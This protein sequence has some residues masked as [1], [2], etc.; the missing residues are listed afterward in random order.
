MLR[1]VQDGFERLRRDRAWLMPVLL[2]EC[3]LLALVVV[4]G[5]VLRPDTT[6]HPDR[7]T[8]NVQNCDLGTPG[9]AQVSFTVTNADKE[10]HDYQVHLLVA[11]AGSAQVGSGSVLVNHVG[12]GAT[13]TARALVPVT[14]GQAGATCVI[15]AEV[16]SGSTGHH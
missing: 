15:R 16:F 4:L 13:V 8:T 5:I 14:G 3:G 10:S 2:V 11:G 7:V 12:A 9:A 6:A 1:K